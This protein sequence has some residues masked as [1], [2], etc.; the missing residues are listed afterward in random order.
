MTATL[1]GLHQSVWTERAR[2]ALEHH[3]VAY[4][5]HEHLPLAGELLLRHKAGVKK[6]SVPLFAD[7][8]VV[9]MGSADIARQA[10]KIGKGPK[11]FTDPAVDHW[12]DVAERLANAGRACFFA[13]ALAS[14]AVQRECVPKL[15][16]RAFLGLAAPTAATVIRYLGRKWDVPTD[17]PAVVA[18]AMRPALEKVRAKLAGG[19]YLLGDFGFADLAIASTL[20]VVE[21]PPM[22]ALGPA[23]KA[24][25]TVPAV[26]ADFRDLLDWRDGIY[27]RHR[28]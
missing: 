12:I 3:R 9:V 4:D 14:P 11:L 2:W 5:F 20:G 18:N 7:G 21:P 27:A 10:E 22:S 28:Q 17:V 6:A 25:W 26:A 8:D 13:K 1:Y 16:P 23:T 24:A 15:I 19:A